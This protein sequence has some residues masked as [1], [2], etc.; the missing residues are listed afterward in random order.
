MTTYRRR[1]EQQSEHHRQAALAAQQR[2]LFDMLGKAVYDPDL[3]AVLDTFGA[4]WTP[5]CSGNTCSPTRCTRMPCS[6]G[7]SAS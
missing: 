1:C 6:P 2:L 3:A 7:A 4:P 5:G